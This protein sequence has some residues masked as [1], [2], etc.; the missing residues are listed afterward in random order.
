MIYLENNQ[1]VKDEKGLFIASSSGNY[2]DG[3]LIEFYNENSPGIV[4]GVFQAQYVKYGGMVYRF[5]GHA[6]LGAEILKIDPESTHSAASY[7]RMSNELLA[8]MDEG[9]LESDSLEKILDE[10]KEK[11]DEE[12]INTEE[13]SEIESEDISDSSDTPEVSTPVDSDTSSTVDS[14]A[15]V[16]DDLSTGSGVE[17]PGDTP[18]VDQSSSELETQTGSDT[19]GEVFSPEQEPSGELLGFLKKKTTRKRKIT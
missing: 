14:G 3:D 9:K 1:S 19:S 17:N 16:S 12:L 5:N 13:A 7:V 15:G 18:P 2:E 4:A 8:Q 10:E 6:E 11:M